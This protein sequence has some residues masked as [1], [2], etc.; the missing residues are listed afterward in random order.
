MRQIC[1]L[2]DFAKNGA[3]GQQMDQ[4]MGKQSAAPKKQ[5][6]FNSVIHRYAQCCL[7]SIFFML[8]DT[9]FIHILYQKIT[10]SWKYC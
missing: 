4:I 1:M 3:D 5:S 2:I 10:F 7:Y 6:F 9:E 8:A